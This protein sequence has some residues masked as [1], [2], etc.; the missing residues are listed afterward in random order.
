MT[1]RLQ[2]KKNESRRLRAGHLWIFSNEVDT[3]LTPLDQFEPGQDVEVVDEKGKFMGHAYVNPHSLICARLVSR[4]P[5]HPFDSSLLVHRL[6]IALSLRQR[7]FADPY[8]RLGYCESD[9]L[10]GLV[11]DRFGDLISVQITTV[12]MERRKDEI[13]TALEKVLKPKTIILRND[14]SIRELEG[15]DSYVDTVVGSAPEYI[16]IIES[17]CR[18]QAD[19]LT[20][21]K[22]GWFYDHRLNR[23]RA[24]QYAKGLRVLDVFSYLGGW[25]IPAAV[26]GAKEVV[27]VDNSAR[28]LELVR[29][30]AGL[31]NVA[32]KVHTHAGDAFEILR[33]LR[34]ERQRFDMIIL[35]PP[36]FIKRR[37]DA[38]NGLE[39]YR[40]IN[41]LAMSLLERDGIL[42]SAS[43]SYHLERER[44]HDLL[45]KS[46]R[47]MDRNLVLL[48]QGHQGPDH[49]VHPA[50]PESDYLKSFICR[51]L[52]N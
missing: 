15:L 19:A 28:A 27:F 4:D 2:L 35:D 11:V 44:L 13:I 34:D 24:S 49:P 25:G 33:G 38:A 48:E 41:S 6:N 26:N 17:G 32:D 14:S 51:V 43:C 36:A 9:G 8:Y 21:Q 20:G 12:G 10:P 37:K 31:N 22:T 23:Q 18:Y 52:P 29:H 47:H 5:K 46:S 50:I 1:A 45:L 42:V 40:R 30:N 16:D 7:L 3:R 39:A